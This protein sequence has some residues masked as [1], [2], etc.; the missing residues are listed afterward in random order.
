LG[1]GRALCI[2]VDTS[3]GEGGPTEADASALAQ[4]A[5]AQG[6][7]PP[8]LLLGAQA[9]RAHVCTKLHE[10]ANACHPGDLFMLTF[11]GHGGRK[12]CGDSASRDGL[13]GIWTLF[14]GS[15]ND[16][17]MRA[18]LAAFRPGVRVLVISD[19]CNGGVPA[20]EHDASVSNIA[21]S[22]LV[23]SACRHDQFAD[24]AGLP[25]HFTTALLHAWH[26]DRRI[27]GY[28]RFHESIAAAMPAY[29]QP[30][31]FSLGSHDARFEAQPPFTV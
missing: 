26:G 21:A 4:V 3:E 18:A 24:A 6:F 28:R 10:A 11:S 29:Q 16:S 22:V 12:H 30:S 13:R 1:T 19:S 27:A 15:L 8:E 17:E 9:T 14:D 25:G 7:Y 31:Y 2:G 5:S 23:L 20:D